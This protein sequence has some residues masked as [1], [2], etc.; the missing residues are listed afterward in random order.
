MHSSPHVLHKTPHMSLRL[1]AAGP[2]EAP[3]GRHF[4]P[5]RDAFWEIIY[6]RA[7]RIEGHVGSGTYQS[8]PGLL[9]VIPPGVL[10]SETA[11]T[12]YTNFWIQINV[13]EQPSWPHYCYDDEMRMFGHLCTAIV[14]EYS[15]QASDREHMLDALL[16]QLD[17]YLRRAHEHYQLPASERLVCQAEQLLEERFATSISIT[18]IA[19]EIGISPSH[20]RAQFV[21]LR[22]QTPMTYLH[23]LRVQQALRLIRNST[24]T[25]EVIAGFCGYD[26]AS[27]L[28]RHIKRATGMRPGA[29]REQEDVSVILESRST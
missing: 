9:V 8:E 18:E 5:H 16:T 6:Y 13:P 10:H 11:H 23:T 25:L 14:R 27:H 26:S 7:G 17:I 20:L 12:A 4:P 2:Y 19:E 15:L 22:G 24:L 3:Q 28:S 29:F 21:R 1:H